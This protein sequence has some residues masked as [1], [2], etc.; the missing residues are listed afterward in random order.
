MSAFFA[1]GEQS[2]PPQNMPC[3][4]RDYFELRAVEKKQGT[5]NALRTPPTCLQAVQNFVV[6][7]PYPLHQE[8]EK[9]I[10]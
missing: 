3:W 2:M 8:G 1:E 5:R 4:C 10:A 6:M 7:S 9:L